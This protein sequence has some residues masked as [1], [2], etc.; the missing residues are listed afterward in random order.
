MIYKLHK[1]PD[2]FTRSQCSMYHYV[3]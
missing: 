1:F 2:P 3:P